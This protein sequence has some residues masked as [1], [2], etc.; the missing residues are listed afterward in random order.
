MSKSHKKKHHT[1]FNPKKWEAEQD[2][3]PVDL[4]HH[5]PHCELWCFLQIP[6][7]AEIKGTYMMTE[8]QRSTITAVTF[9][10]SSNA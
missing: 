7:L 5:D 3:H 1:G 4:S 6:A 2:R 8:A 10:G 9:G